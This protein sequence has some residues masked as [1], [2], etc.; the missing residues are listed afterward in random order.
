MVLVL[1]AGSTV[2]QALVR[3]LT[4]RARSHSLPFAPSGFAM[5]CPNVHW[6]VIW[7]P[8]GT[9]ASPGRPSL[10]T[11]PA[12][13]PGG[14]DQAAFDSNCGPATTITASASLAASAATSW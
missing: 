5:P 7:G 4:D 14:D 13:T 6:T 11:P 3:L 2:A 9:Q 8:G 10:W 12:P 1:T